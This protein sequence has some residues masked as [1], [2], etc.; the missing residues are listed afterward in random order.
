MCLE[1]SHLVFMYIDRNVEYAMIVDVIR[2][3]DYDSSGKSQE[4]RVESF[5]DY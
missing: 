4:A 1:S 2:E 5:I 3:N